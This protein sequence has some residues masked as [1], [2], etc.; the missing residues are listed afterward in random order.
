MENKITTE[1][2]NEYAWICRCG[3][4]PEEDGFYPCDGAGNL[5]EPTP[6]EW[7][8]NWYVC[9]RCGVMVDQHTLVIVGQA[10]PAVVQSQF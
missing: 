6:E 10:D 7:T 8:T 3:N 2:G 5:V 9:A 4:V 1:V